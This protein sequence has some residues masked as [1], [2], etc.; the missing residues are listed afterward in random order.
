MS[1]TAQSSMNRAAIL[2]Q[3][4]NIFTHMIRGPGSLSHYF[5]TEGVK[6]TPRKPLSSLVFGVS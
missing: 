2:C 3:R 4:R 5:V 6:I 1:T